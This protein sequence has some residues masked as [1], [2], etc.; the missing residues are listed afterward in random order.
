MHRDAMIIN[1]GILCQFR[2]ISVNIEGFS[3]VESSRSFS[4]ALPLPVVVESL[5]SFSAAIPLSLPVVT[6]Y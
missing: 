4:A 5:R 3:L 2:I 6:V 1:R